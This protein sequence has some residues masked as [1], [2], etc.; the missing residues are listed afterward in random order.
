MMF[1]VEEGHF[2]LVNITPWSVFIFPGYSRKRVFEAV[3]GDTPGMMLSVEEGHF[4]LVM[5]NPWSTLM[6]PEASPLVRGATA[7]P[8]AFPGTLQG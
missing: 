7:A 3:V 2:I 4:I 6:F 8:G 1:S 5:T